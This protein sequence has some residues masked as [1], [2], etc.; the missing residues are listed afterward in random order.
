MAAYTY[1][2]GWSGHNK[3]YYGVRYAVNCS[4]DDLFN[5]YFTSSKHVKQFFK[6]NG[7]PDIIQIRKVFE[8]KE[9]AINWE[10]RV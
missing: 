1:R 8:T 10:H 5:S 6:L 4:P 7:K 9:Q 2:I 3:H